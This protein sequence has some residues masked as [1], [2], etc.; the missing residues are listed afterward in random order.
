MKRLALMLLSFAILSGCTS[1]PPP[2]E[3]KKVEPPELLTGRSAFQQLYI[4]A[5]GWAGDVRPYMLQSEVIGNNKGKDGKAVLWRGAFASAQMRGSKPYVW[6]GIDAPDAPARGI[7]PGT[8]DS[9]SPSNSFDVAFL[10]IDSDKALEIAQKHGGDK[11]GD[12]PVLYS[13]EWNRP[14]NN[15]IWHVIYGNSRN[16][17]KLTVD[18]D[19]STGEFIRKE[20]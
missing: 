7:S 6:S 9:Y 14:G 19:A 4:A 5:R 2:P 10:K 15:L 16:D 20:K 1:A 3:Q 11:V 13:L 17:A 8:Q 18:V 12:T